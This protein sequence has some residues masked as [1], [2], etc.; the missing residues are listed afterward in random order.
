MTG[1][2]TLPDDERVA[3]WAARRI[4]ELLEQARARHEVA[5]VALSGGRTPLRTYELL[6]QQAVQWDAI[7]LWFVDERCVEPEH[8]QSNYRTVQTALLQR[9]PAP[10]RRVQRMRGELGADAGAQLYA[11]L[12]CSCVPPCV[13]GLPAL[14]VAV[15]GTGPEGHV[16][17]LFPDAPALHVGAQAI[18]LGVHDSPK[19]PPERIT[20][21]LA[22]LRAARRC[23][24]IAT[25]AEKA[26]A[27]AAALG[28]PTP[29]APVSLLRRE[30]L[31]VI[32]DD[33]AAAPPGAPL[34]APPGA[35]PGA[36]R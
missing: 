12:L 15:L 8:E 36:E 3:A 27:V 33:A 20:L 19:P 17:S 11:E 10:P 1:V 35:A 29:R 25:G 6:A 5:R 14:D 7:E 23:V 31:E 32:V 13:E 26:P 22:M 34:G 9:L 4:A 24:L 2:T 21:S 18:C 16:A 30:R 28:E